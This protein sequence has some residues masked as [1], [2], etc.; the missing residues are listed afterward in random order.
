MSDFLSWDFKNLKVK[1]VYSLFWPK[2]NALWHRM[3]GN[4]PIPEA[5]TRKFVFTSEKKFLCVVGPTS[6]HENQSF[7]FRVSLIR[8][9]LLSTLL[10]W[11][12]VYWPCAGDLMEGQH[13]HAYVT[14]HEVTMTVQEPA[15]YNQEGSLKQIVSWKEFQTNW[16]QDRDWPGSKILF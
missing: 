16:A 2:L 14:V 9:D 11:C 12:G 7:S 13:K 6:H 3:A 4:P 5:G 10:Y 8:R 15:F 1:F